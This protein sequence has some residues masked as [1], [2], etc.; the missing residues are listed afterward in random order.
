MWG[1]GL[2][3]PN[4]HSIVAEASQFLKKCLLLKASAS[5]IGYNNKA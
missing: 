1:F 3:N 5:Q 4:S 2:E